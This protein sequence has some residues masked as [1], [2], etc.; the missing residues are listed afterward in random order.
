MAVLEL[1]QF[2]QQIS[3]LAREKCF[4]S[5][6]FR[7]FFEH[8]FSTMVGSQGGSHCELEEQGLGGRWKKVDKEKVAFFIE[9][10]ITV[11]DFDKLRLV[12]NFPSN[13]LQI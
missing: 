1:G 5:N 10:R 7:R 11:Q 2:F 4:H 3:L 6:I 9:K 13:F 12:F 8:I